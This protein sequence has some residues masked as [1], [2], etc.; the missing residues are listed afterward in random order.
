MMTI[1]NAAR[2]DASLIADAII[3]AIGPAITA[4]LAGEEHTREEVHALFESLAAREDTQY[5][6]LN[7]R[8][9]VDDDGKPMGVCVSYDGADLIRLRRKFFSEANK[10]LGWD[11]NLEEVDSFPGETEPDEYYLD[12]L[13]TL[14][15]F[16]GH[17]VAT[18][19]IRDAKEK[20]DQAGKPLGLL[21]DIDNNRARKLYDRV[22]FKECGLRPF[23]GHMMNH[24]QL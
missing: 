19:L 23:A 4:G 11:L 17:G 21:C 18:A 24:L 20:A 2:E 1:R 5:S 12:T 9:A 6:F 3:S 16:R 8:I 13:M 15:Q 7:S 22:G 10:R 14:P